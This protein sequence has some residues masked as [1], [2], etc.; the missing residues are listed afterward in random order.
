MITTGNLIV[1][2]FSRNKTLVLLTF[3]ACITGS[4]LNVLLPLSIGKFYEL[5]FQEGSTKVK[6]FDTLR[7]PV[8]PINSFFSFFLLLIGLKS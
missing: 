2:F 4:L 3:V 5:L 1:K 7:I 8:D 6:L